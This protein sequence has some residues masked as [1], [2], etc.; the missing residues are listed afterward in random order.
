MKRA[1]GAIAVYEDPK[2]G[3]TAVL[4]VRKSDDSF[5]DCVEKTWGGGA[6][7]DEK[8]AMALCRE[9]GE[10]VR[11]VSARSGISPSSVL[12]GRR[13][14]ETTIDP[15]MDSTADIIDTDNRGYVLQRLN[16][17]REVGRKLVVTLLCTIRDEK[18]IAAIQPL[19][20]AGTLVKITA[21]G[22]LRLVPI[23]A[24]EHKTSGL[25]SDQRKEGKLGM[26]PDEIEA[27]RIALGIVKA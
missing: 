25:P 10:E 9:Y 5:P 16:E 26:F 23:N 6:E 17:F 18:I 14:P 4:Q 24:A 15:E 2:E 8:L 21:A 7:Q 20:D 3:R 27:V 12:L 22:F 19:A 11:E 1:I 13:K